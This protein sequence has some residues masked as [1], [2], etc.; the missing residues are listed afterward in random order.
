MAYYGKHDDSYGYGHGGYIEPGGPESLWEAV[1]YQVRIKQKA[2]AYEMLMRHFSMI[3]S[4]WARDSVRGF[5]LKREAARCA[6]PKTW[7]V[8]KVVRASPSEAGL[9]YSYHRSYVYELGKT[10]KAEPPY[11]AWRCPPSH[12]PRGCAV[13]RCSAWRPLDDPSIYCC[14]W[15]AIRIDAVTVVEELDPND[16]IPF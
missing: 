6:A 16:D 15:A 1:R 11:W 12:V 7:T 8:Y 5:F 4:G 9:F 2:G 3:Q 13:V 10:Y 14:R